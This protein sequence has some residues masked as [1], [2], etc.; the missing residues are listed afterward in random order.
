MA[1]T[2]KSGAS[3]EGSAELLSSDAGMSRAAPLSRGVAWRLLAAIFL[4]SSAVTLL[5]TLLELYVDYRG[6]LQDIRDRFSEIE[7]GLS[8]EPWGEYVE[9]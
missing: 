7:K 8:G 4:F 9:P 6:Q 1:E 2:D 5:T 3:A